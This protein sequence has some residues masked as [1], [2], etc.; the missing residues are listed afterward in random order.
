MKVG[1]LLYLC[2]VRQHALA[3]DAGTGQVRWR[4]DPQIEVGHT[5]QHLTC[6]GLAYFD[7]AS[8]PADARANVSTN[9]PAN[10]LAGAPASVQPATCARSIFLPTIDARLFA[11]NA[12]TGDRCVDFGDQGVVDLSA[13]MPNLK[14]G[15]YM[16]TSPPVVAGGVVIVGGSIN[17]NASVLNPSGVIRAFD[18]RSGRLV[19]AFDPGRP[20][21]TAPLPPGQTYT[22]GA[23]NNWAP[24]SVDA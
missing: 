8:A 12:Q 20:D 14:A 11:L 17:D 4:F 23:P 2:S 10:V 18:A 22:A 6:R 21:A 9:V 1:D 15:A 16:Q 5:S 7:G 13:G 24:S 3:L 19:W